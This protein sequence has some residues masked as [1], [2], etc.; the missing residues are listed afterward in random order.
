MGCGGHPASSRCPFAPDAQLRAAI[1]AQAA[2]ARCVRD[3]RG[4]LPTELSPC[5]VVGDAIKCECGAAAELHCVSCNA[6]CCA[7]CHSLPFQ[8]KH[9]TTPPQRAAAAAA[10]C[11]AHPGHKLELVCDQDGAH[12]CLMCERGDHR[13]HR[14]TPIADRA[15]Q[16]RQQQE[17]QLSAL[18]A[19]LEALAGALPG[20]LAAVEAK[21]GAI[22]QAPT[23]LRGRCACVHSGRRSVCRC[24]RG[25]RKSCARCAHA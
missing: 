10:M 18:G 20:A 1:A 14:T 16:Q 22:E 15:R 4:P 21:I 12:I 13:D 17:Q 2:G 19:R 8:R 3:A 23:A 9:A 7:H 24:A 6:N 25:C 11:S 5:T